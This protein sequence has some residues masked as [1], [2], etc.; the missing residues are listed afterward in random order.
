MENNTVK[1]LRTQQA[2]KNT[3]KDTNY[4]TIVIY[5]FYNI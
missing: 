5:L 1:Y 4:K 3:V 2:Q